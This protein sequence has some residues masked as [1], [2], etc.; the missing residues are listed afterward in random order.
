MLLNPT[1]LQTEGPEAYWAKVALVAPFGWSFFVLL[2]W[3]KGQWMNATFCLCSP[4][5][6]GQIWLPSQSATHEDKMF[7]E[8]FSQH[9]VIVWCQVV[10]SCFSGSSARA[11]F[12]LLVVASGFGEWSLLKL[13]NILAHQMSYL[14]PV[15]FQQTMP[16]HLRMVSKSDLTF[17]LF[18][19]GLYS[20]VHRQSQLHPPPFCTKQRS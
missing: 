1:G 16:L 6:G 15:C 7:I 4:S 18:D 17:G 12:L 9:F 14:K 19:M 3:K 2:V 11:C 13:P 10:A 20:K 5:H 8:V